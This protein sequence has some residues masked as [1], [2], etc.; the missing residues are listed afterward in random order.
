LRGRRDD[1]RINEE[2]PLQNEEN[3]RQLLRF[4]LEAGDTV[5]GEHL[6]N[7]GSNATY[8]SKTTQNQLIEACGTV[9]REVISNRIKEAQFF[10]VVFDK[11]TGALFLK[12]MACHFLYKKK[13]I[14]K[15][16]GMP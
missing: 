10:S 9:V 16:S 2:N 13:L 1:G 14:C 4:S 11:T 12:I 6:Q 15:E 3:F 8:I 5:L 7:S